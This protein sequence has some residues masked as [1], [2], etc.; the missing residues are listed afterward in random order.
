MNPS[1]ALKTFKTFKT[2]MDIW[3]PRHLLCVKE[4]T[5]LY[6]GSDGH[7]K[8]LEPVQRSAS[9]EYV[10][11]DVISIKTDPLV[12]IQYTGDRILVATS[13]TLMTVSVQGKRIHLEKVH[14]FFFSDKVY[15]FCATRD[16]IYALS[17]SAILGTRVNCVNM[18]DLSELE[19]A[20]FPYKALSLHV[21]EKGFLVFALQLIWTYDKSFKS[22]RLAFEVQD[23]TIYAGQVHN[24][25]AYATIGFDNILHAIDVHSGVT[26]QLRS[27]PTFHFA[28][29][30]YFNTIVCAG[31]SY[32]M[33]LLS[34]ISASL[35]EQ[36]IKSVSPVSAQVSSATQEYKLCIG[37]VGDVSNYCV[38]SQSS[39][40]FI[41]GLLPSSTYTITTEEVTD[42]FQT[43]PD[44]IQ[45]YKETFKHLADASY[46]SDSYDFFKFPEAGPI[47]PY[48]CKQSRESRAFVRVEILEHGVARV[49]KLKIAQPGD[50]VELGADVDG[51][52]TV[53]DKPIQVF[54]RL[55]DQSPPQSVTINA[56]SSDVIRIGS[57]FFYPGETLQSTL[58]FQQTDDVLGLGVLILAKSNLICTPET[59]APRPQ[60]QNSGKISSDVFQTNRLIGIADEHGMYKKVF[61]NNDKET[62]RV[63]FQEGSFHL[64]VCADNAASN[65]SPMCTLRPRTQ[66]SCDLDNI[67]FYGEK[68]KMVMDEQGLSLDC[69]Q[70]L[71]IG[72]HRISCDSSKMYIE[73]YNDATKQFESCAMIS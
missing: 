39:S 17:Y 54:L 21:V 43:L 13:S 33:N 59:I 61:C 55:T 8:R 31:P 34:S 24:D 23:G 69:G 62:A 64:A 56:L 30:N 58:V 1:N 32:S 68:S 65:Q 73:F 3:Y 37:C 6:D 66:I 38:S 2:S 15:S 27:A 52:M 11:Y 53:A 49:V 40:K 70:S 72:N 36:I 25:V 46:L 63:S 50:S 14:N 67:I 35:R 57:V 19:V 16:V 18:A 20:H 71:R 29:S 51:I 7:L 10:E 5:W 45:N 60:I 48:A 41:F 4:I 47:L 9:T 22:P 44:S 26:T 12:G 42:T 28:L